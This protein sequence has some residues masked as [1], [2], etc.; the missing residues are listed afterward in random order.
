MDKII[1]RRT[2]EDTE[3]A[4]GAK[5]FELFW[6]RPKKMNSHEVIL[7]MKINQ[8]WGGWK[9]KDD[10]VKSVGL[11]VGDTINTE[12]S[13]LNTSGLIDDSDDTDLFASGEG[14]D[15]LLNNDV[16]LGSVID[17]KVRFV[18]A[19][20]P[21]GGLDGKEIWKISLVFIEGY[22]I[23]EERSTKD[24]HAQFGETS[25]LAALRKLL[26]E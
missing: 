14:A 1:A 9:L 18:Y 15:W 17:A 6:L 5:E 11:D 16:G 21:V 22:N 23:I 2:V 3:L 13:I 24:E 19:K 10:L 7:R 4:K 20:A 12:V 26:S 25:T 8:R